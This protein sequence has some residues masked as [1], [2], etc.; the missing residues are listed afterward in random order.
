VKKWSYEKSETAKLIS[1]MQSIQNFNR[2]DNP[3]K[4]ALYGK[5][6]MSTLTNQS[7]CFYVSNT[8]TYFPPQT[9]FAEGPK[10]QTTTTHTK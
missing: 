3:T 6:Q 9:L 4:I 7:G 1:W 8:K 10:S 5:N 2:K